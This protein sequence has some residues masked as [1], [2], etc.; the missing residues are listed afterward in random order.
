MWSL[1]LG[2]SHTQFRP[3]EQDFINI[4]RFYKIFSLDMLS[5]DGY[6]AAPDSGDSGCAGGYSPPRRPAA[7]HA[8]PSTI[9]TS[10]DCAGRILRS[11]TRSSL[12]QSAM[13]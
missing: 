5:A 2:K 13:R 11:I 7:N 3:F 9:E 8:P 10:R 1:W 6:L 12:I 4:L